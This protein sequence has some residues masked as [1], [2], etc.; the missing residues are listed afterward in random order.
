MVHGNYVGV[1]YVIYLTR[2][3]DQYDDLLP[4]CISARKMM[5]FHKNDP[6][7]ICVFG[8][9]TFNKQF[10][11][12]VESQKI[13]KA[14]LELSYSRID[15]SQRKEYPELFLYNDVYVYSEKIKGKNVI[16]VTKEIYLEMDERLDFLLVKLKNDELIIED[17]T[18]ELSNLKKELTIQNIIYD[19]EYL[20]KVI[21]IEKKVIDEI[22]FTSEQKEIIEI[23][24]NHPKLE[25]L[26]QKIG[27]EI[28]TGTY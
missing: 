16:V 14:I 1:N 26:I 13:T 25:G 3:I 24:R 11:K 21:D 4:I 5:T 23:I 17:E 9:E 27:L 20:Q 18:G 8:Y 19:T 2:P 12:S 10:Q 6:T 28:T 15:M 7:K 22:E